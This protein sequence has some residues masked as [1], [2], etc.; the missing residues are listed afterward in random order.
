[1]VVGKMEYWKVGMMEEWKMEIWKLDF[2][3]LDIK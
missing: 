1:M 2:W 3:K